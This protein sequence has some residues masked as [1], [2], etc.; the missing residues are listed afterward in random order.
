MKGWWHYLKEEKRKKP[1]YL[2]CTNVHVS[3]V[4]IIKYYAIRWKIEQMIKD[5]KQLLGFGDY[6]VRDLQA[7]KLHV[8]LVLLSYFV[9]ILLILKI[10]QWLKDK[11]GCLDVSIRQLGMVQGGRP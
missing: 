2:V 11:R 1:T 5:L 7:I 3:A 8:A 6:Q 10:L 4:D 9:L